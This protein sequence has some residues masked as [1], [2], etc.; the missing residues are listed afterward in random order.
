M[1]CEKEGSLWC[2]SCDN[3]WKINPQAAACGFCGSLGSFRSCSGCKE[4]VYLDGLSFV[5]SYADP[6]IRKMI[7]H[8]KYY[9]DLSTE[10][11]FKS[12]LQR[13][14]SRVCPPAY[15]FVVSF[16]PLH[17]FKKRERGFDQAEEVSRL[18][19][20]IYGLPQASLLK[21]T[22]WTRSQ[23]PLSSTERKVG[24]LD[25]VFDVV[26]SVPS[27]VLLCDDVFTSGATMD[28]AAKCL[29]DNGAKVVWGF[30]LAKG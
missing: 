19:S 20:N 13:D 22:K 6:I 15:P 23:A 10:H 3:V 1:R 8:W 29:K 30:T 9:G 21:R 4:C 28:A 14:A 25:G 12:W 7:A 5:G 2:D 17:I 18:V 24:V 26:G 27:T 11:V 16:L